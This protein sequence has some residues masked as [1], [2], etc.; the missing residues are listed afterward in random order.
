MMSHI[1]KG[2]VYTLAW[3]QLISLIHTVHGTTN[4]EICKPKD[5]SS[6]LIS[7]VLLWLTS[8]HAMVWLN[9]ILSCGYFNILIWVPWFQYDNIVSSE[10]NGNYWQFWESDN[11]H[12][13]PFHF[14]LC[15]TNKSKV[16]YPTLKLNA[17]IIQQVHI[18][19]DR[20]LQW[21]EKRR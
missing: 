20:Y 16:K 15:N 10:G 5:V 19:C 4:Q 2:L 7:R 8:V 11:D 21:T 12:G 9:N 3:C 13:D 17:Y 18:T 6:C 1:L 14:L